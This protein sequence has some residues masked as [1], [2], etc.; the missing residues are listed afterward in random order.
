MGRAGCSFVGGLIGYFSGIFCVCFFFGN[1][2]IETSLCSC[3]RVLRV[4]EQNFLKNVVN[5]SHSLKKILNA[6]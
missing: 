3:F 1:D 5:V 6:M 4:K 2:L